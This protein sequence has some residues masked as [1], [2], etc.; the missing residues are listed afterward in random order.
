M[1]L[2]Y[3]AG[4]KDERNG[5]YGCSQPLTLRRAVAKDELDGTDDDLQQFLHSND[6]LPYMS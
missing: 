4:P 1:D 5:E 3:S 2:W 6:R